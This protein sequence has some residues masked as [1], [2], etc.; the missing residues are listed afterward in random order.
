MGRILVFFLSL[1][2]FLF[3]SVPFFSSRRIS[4]GILI[5][6]GYFLNS[7][8]ILGAREATLQYETL[9]TIPALAPQVAYGQDMLATAL[10]EVF[11]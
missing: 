11:L 2:C 1:H 3:L 4:K 9:G 5:V 10:P 8:D 7:Q 6:L